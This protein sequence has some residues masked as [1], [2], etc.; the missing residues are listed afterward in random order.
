MNRKRIV[1]SV[2][3]SVMHG[4]CAIVYFQLLY[5]AIHFGIIGLNLSWKRGS[6]GPSLM[7]LDG[8]AKRDR[9]AR[10]TLQDWKLGE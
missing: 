1:V 9:K 7:A 10:D 8:F 5:R 4:L 6:S 2:M 3:H